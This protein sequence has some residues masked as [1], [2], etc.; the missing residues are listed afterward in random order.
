M[1]VKSDAVLAAMLKGLVRVVMAD[2]S[3][4]WVKPDADK[5]R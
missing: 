5:K 4:W 2:G 1:K 3:V